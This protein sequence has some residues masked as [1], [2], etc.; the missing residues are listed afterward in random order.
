M[1]TK[2]FLGKGSIYV[3]EIGSGNGLLPI[4]NCS[5]LD[6]AFNE[7]KKEQKDYE[8]AGGAVVDSVS[9]I[10]SVVAS[11]T[12]LSL[13][14]KNVA[15]ALRGLV[16]TVVAG[17]VTT[18]AHASVML[19]AL[20]KF[21]FLPDM[22]VAPVI[23][24]TGATPV[25]VAGTDYTVK[26]GGIVI[27]SGGTITDSTDIEV[28]YTKLASMEV[29]AL[30]ASGKEY[31]FVFDG[32]NEADSGKPVML[33]CHRCKFN[34]TQALSMISDDFGNLPLTLDILK[35]DS[36]VGTGLSKFM[37]ISMAQ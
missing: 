32:L 15:L 9:R 14:P 1:A 34:P 28:N 19:G 18:E 30:S 27:L 5:N 4:G 13:D 2:S 33:E 22:T 37:K 21:V 16:N 35:D 25:Y 17:A 11:V 24:G 29:E 31:R 3:E 36:I 6:F 26:N 12:A 8:E 23:T 20:V 7:D 10:D